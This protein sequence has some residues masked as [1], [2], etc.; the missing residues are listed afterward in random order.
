MTQVPIPEDKQK[1]I[2][3][4]LQHLVDVAFQSS[5][6]VAIDEARAMNDPYLLDAFHDTLVDKLYKE[7]ITRHKLDEL[8]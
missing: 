8:K 1:D 6:T 2:Q 7:L 4:K 5:L 3:E